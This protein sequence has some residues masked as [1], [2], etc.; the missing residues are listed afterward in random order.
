MK[1]AIILIID[2]LGIGAMSDAPLY[3]DSLECN[4]LAHIAAHNNGLEIPNLRN[5]GLAN[6]VPLKNISP[7]DMPVASFGKMMESSKGKDSTTG[8]WE[9]A[10]LVSEQGFATFPNGFPLE[11]MDKF[12]ESTGCGGYLGNIP[13]SGTAI[14]DQFHEEH[15]STG[16]PIIY[17]SADSVFQIACDIN[18]VPV[19]E[20]Y[21]WCEKARALLD[22]GYNCSRV[23][24]RPYEETKNG[25]SRLGSLRKD[26]SVP[27][28]PGSVLN[29]VKDNKGRVI[30]I[31]KT[32][33]LFVGSGITHSVHTG[34]NKEGLE[35]TLDAIR[36][37][38]PLVEIALNQADADHIER[39]LIF[40]NLVDTDMIYGHRRDAKGYGMALEDIDKS[41]E[42]IIKA[43]GVDD[44]LII[45]ADHGCDPT[46][47]G[48]DHTREMVPLLI[49]NPALTSK[50]MET[51]PSFTYVAR[52]VADWLDV[53]SE[54]S[55][56][57]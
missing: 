54:T 29:K 32:E 46:S 52:L 27:P 33:D 11:L 44:L 37:E 4:T 13:A 55:W 8:H 16:Y 48:T 23:I 2:S 6:I 24:A 43:I 49:Y 1:R 38:L 20:L 28:P 7:V 57:H 50:Q 39:E 5:M 42:A 25:P 18:I 35:K 45:T 10:G 9:I 19:E 3:G 30:A 47:P 41:L 14:I 56:A 21:H 15:K 34:N 12:V 26:Y 53:E 51:K 40:T 31:G 22:Q 36:R 17:T